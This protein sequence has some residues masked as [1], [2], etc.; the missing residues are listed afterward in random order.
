M[1]VPLDWPVYHPEMPLKSNAPKKWNREL[2]MSCTSF[3]RCQL[4]P[5]KKLQSLRSL[6]AS[7]LAGRGGLPDLKS[8]LR[9]S[10]QILPRTQRSAACSVPNMTALSAVSSTA[11]APARA[12]IDRP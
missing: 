5:L 11:A 4:L 2:N 12:V 1:K 8:L 9:V 3:R 10:A 7:L 6:S